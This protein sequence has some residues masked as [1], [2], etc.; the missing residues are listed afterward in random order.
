MSNIGSP[1]PKGHNT[2]Y[3][4]GTM[5]YYKSTEPS[6]LKDESLY[7]E[8]IKKQGDELQKA[9]RVADLYKTLSMLLL[10]ECALLGLGI[11]ILL[12]K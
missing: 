7:I 1:N 12:S 5:P 4:G 10:L 11:Y 3:H 2:K 8:T 6:S 9:R